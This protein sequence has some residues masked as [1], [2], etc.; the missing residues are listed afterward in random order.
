MPGIEKVA[1]RPR[2]RVHL[3]RLVKSPALQALAGVNRPL[4]SQ[5]GT[6]PSGTDKVTAL[7]PSGRETVQQMTLNTPWGLDGPP[8][9]GDYSAHSTV[10]GG[11]AA[12]PVPDY[13]ATVSGAPSPLW[14]RS[15]PVFLGPCAARPLA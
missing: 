8:E 6:A 12:G 10:A 4:V 2:P 14:F 7:G 15:R 9:R 13:G 5:T 3:H 1:L 11:E